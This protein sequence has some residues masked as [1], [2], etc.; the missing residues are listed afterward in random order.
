MQPGSFLPLTLKVTLD[1]TVIF[2]VIATAVRK[3]AVVTEPAKASELKEEVSTT[4]VTVIVIDCVPALLAASV[5]V[6]V[7]S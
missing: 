6:R 2:A 5:A 3:V 1:A 7:I 4:S